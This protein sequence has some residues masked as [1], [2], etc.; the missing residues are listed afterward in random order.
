MPETRP[1]DAPI[2]QGPLAAAVVRPS[3]E[4]AGPEVRLVYADLDLAERA[5]LRQSLGLSPSDA[6]DDE[7]LVLAAYRR[8]GPCA[9]D[10]LGGP[11]AVAVW[12]GERQAVV[13]FR[14]PVG[15]RPLFWA[16]V[17][18]AV[19]VGGDLRAILST[20]V[21][22]DDLDDAMMAGTLLAP[23]FRPVLFGRTYLR[24]I[25]DLSGGHRLLA[26][27]SGGRTERYWRPEDSPELALRDIDEIGEALREI[28]RVV[29]RESIADDPPE[30][31]G[32]HLSSGIDS[33]TVAAFTAEALDGVA[34][35]AFPWQPPPVSG[36]PLP[37]E[38]RRIE[39]LARRWG[40]PV[41]YCPRGPDDTFAALLL[42]G[43][44]DP[45][46]MWASEAPVRRAAH[47]QGIR[48]LMSGWGGDEAI[49]FS[50][51]SLVTTH[52]A[53]QGRLAPV[54]AMIA[55]D[56][57]DAARRAR[58]VRSRAHIG[59]GETPL[60]EVRRSAVQG[61]VSSFAQLDL[62]R[63]ARIPQPEPPPRDPRRYMAWLLRRGH[64]GDRAASWA[65]A[66]AP[67]GLRYHYP[68]LDRRVLAFALGLP[69]E[70]WLTR[71]RQ[72]RWPLRAAGKE[73]VPDVVRLGGKSEPMWV[74]SGR[75]AKE[76]IEE[77][78][79]PLVTPEAAGARGDVIDVPKVQA[80]LGHT[81]RGGPTHDLQP[82]VGAVGAASYLGLG[83]AHGL[84]GTGPA[85]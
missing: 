20:G 41:T 44:L 60:D 59:R 8:W 38:H 77:R 84:L 28:L 73:W 85:G 37:T 35:P 63:R 48:T 27:A 25:R 19:V 6:S 54:L 57:L 40:L 9:A 52:L 31:V 55:R 67:F 2:A 13:A 71:S 75:Q 68:L 1:P 5:G 43:V 80:A 14:D 82:P 49:S 74:E 45:T 64:V 70:A 4:P 61:E 7:A 23:L 66:G 62:L 81:L 11:F 47:A 29:V 16:T 21:V 58:G 56:P 78:I 18:G 42:D 72:R 79:A 17:D 10:H 76:G 3:E 26:D 83:D 24:A 15:L 39:A 50:G 30:T 51:R 12:D 34:P 22:P 36:A 53:R 46:M 32:V 69:L 33:T 65:R